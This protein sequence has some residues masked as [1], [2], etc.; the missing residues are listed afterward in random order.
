MSRVPSAQRLPSGWSPFRTSTTGDPGGIWPQIDVAGLHFGRSSLPPTHEA[1]S[2]NIGNTLDGNGEE[3]G[4]SVT[5]HY[6]G[7][8][9]IPFPDGDRYWILLSGDGDLELFTCEPNILSDPD[10]APLGEAT[11]MDPADG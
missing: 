5:F 7:F 8:A 6:Q 3:V 2:S 11:G 10:G 4:G 9:E 1:G